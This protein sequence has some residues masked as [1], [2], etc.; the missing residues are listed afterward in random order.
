MR[1]PSP[2]SAYS[3]S[4]SG[5]GVPRGPLPRRLEYGLPCAVS[6]TV[7]PV[8]ASRAIKSCLPSFMPWVKSM[9]PTTA[10]E[11]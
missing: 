10:R 8:S 3:R 4:P 7:S 1:F 9:P 6:Q 11:E 5:V 2:P